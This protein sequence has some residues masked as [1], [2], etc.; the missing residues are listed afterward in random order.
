MTSA[1]HEVRAVATIDGNDTDDP[2]CGEFRQRHSQSKRSDLRSA[3]SRLLRL[4]IVNTTTHSYRNPQLISAMHA[5]IAVATIA[6]NRFFDRRWQI[7][8]KLFLNRRGAGG[9]WGAPTIEDTDSKTAN[10]P[11]P[12]YL[13]AVSG[14][15]RHSQLCACL[16]LSISGSGNDS[17]GGHLISISNTISG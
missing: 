6:G 12:A 2:Q 4:R 13:S 1:V 15:L 7:F 17:A 11:G 8:R 5:G 3:E 10:P 14:G 9:L 16:R